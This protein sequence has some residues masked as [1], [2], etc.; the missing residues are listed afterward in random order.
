MVGDRRCLHSTSFRVRELSWF[1][2]HLQIQIEYALRLPH[3][4][5]FF[6]A[7]CNLS[8]AFFYPLTPTTCFLHAVTTTNALHFAYETTRRDETR[9]LLL[10]QNRLFRG[11]RPA[12]SRPVNIKPSRRHDGVHVCRP[13]PPRRYPL[14]PCHRCPFRG[15]AMSIHGT[16]Y[17]VSRSQVPPLHG[18]SRPFLRRG[19]AKRGRATT[20]HSSRQGTCWRPSHASRTPATTVPLSVVSV[21]KT[22]GGSRC[23]VARSI[24]QTGYSSSVVSLRSVSQYLQLVRSAPSGAVFSILS[25][26]I[27]MNIWW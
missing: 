3:C 27:G 15:A 13:F 9:R 21:P 7:F 10:L 19:H 24:R 18:C 16:R 8:S 2:L 14:S 1:L 26:A 4:K 6:Q 11:I 25:T 22:L 5:E 20:G 23:H 12:A 17:A